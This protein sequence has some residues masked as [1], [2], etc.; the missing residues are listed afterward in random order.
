MR[1]KGWLI[2][3]L[4]VVA[5]AIAIIVVWRYLPKELP[6]HF[7]LQGNASGLMSRSVLPLYPLAS[8]VLSLA[9]YLI[10]RKM[11]KLLTGI[12][13]LISGISLVMFFSTMVTLTSGEYPAF[14][15][16]EPVILLIAVVAF[17][18]CVIKS[19]KKS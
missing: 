13:I 10:S 15:L 18:V 8:A 19:R 4:I 5:N 11:Y 9:A 2:P 6:A 14:M 1:N 16:A 12:I 7:D 17:V 3:I